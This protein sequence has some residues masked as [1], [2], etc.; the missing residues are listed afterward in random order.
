MPPMMPG[1]MMPPRMP[2]A[3]VQPTGPVTLLP[4]YSI[5]ALF[6]TSSKYT[7]ICKTKHNK[8]HVHFSDGLTIYVN[9]QSDLFIVTTS[10]PF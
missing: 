6:H 10:R 7:T 5:S 9:E 2:S 8:T 4:P 1:M 3:A